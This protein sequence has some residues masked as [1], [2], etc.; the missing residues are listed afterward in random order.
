MAD[1][2]KLTVYYDGACPMC[3]REIALLRRLDQRRALI[4][5]ENI[6]PVDAVPS[7]DISKT[8][9][10]ARFHARLPDGRMVEGAQAFTEAWSQV[11]WLIWMRPLGRFVPTRWLMNRV[12]DGFLK[13]RPAL[14]KRLAG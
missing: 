7:C 6:A 8:K 2:D 3:I 14:Q 1:P 11:P 12:Y 9:L 5:F 4:V 13:I 10:L